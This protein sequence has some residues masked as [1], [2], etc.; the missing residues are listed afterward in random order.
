VLSPPLVR[1]NPVMAG[2]TFKA[3]GKVIYP[4]LRCICTLPYH[5]HL[6][7]IARLSRLA[8]DGLPAG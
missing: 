1:F 7:A 5:S 8:M 6:S 4:D 2:M 3:G